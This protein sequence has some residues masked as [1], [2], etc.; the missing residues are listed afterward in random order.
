MSASSRVSK[1]PVKRFAVAIARAV[2]S[3]IPSKEVIL[4]LPHAAL[5]FFQTLS[6]FALSSIITSEPSKSDKEIW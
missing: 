1:I 6:G 5:P 2:D 3:S 4:G